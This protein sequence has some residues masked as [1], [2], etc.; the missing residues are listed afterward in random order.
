L[1]DRSSDVNGVLVT[2]RTAA[3]LAALGHA[4]AP[5]DTALTYTRQRNWFAKPLCSF[6]IVQER[7]VKMLAG[8]TGMQLFCVQLPRLEENGRLSDSIA[9]LAKLNN[10]CKAR[11]VGLP[12]PA[13]C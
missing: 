5:Y 11:H 1:A 12:T 9:G 8:V 4:V 3:A 2:T 13:T 6:R 10:T 7:L